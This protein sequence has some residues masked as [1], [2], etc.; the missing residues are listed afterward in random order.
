M[1]EKDSPPTTTIEHPI[2]YLVSLWNAVDSDG[3]RWKDRLRSFFLQLRNEMSPEG[4]KR[5]HW[6]HVG[7]ANSVLCANINESLQGIDVFNSKIETLE[8]QIN[9]RESIESKLL[10][11][12]QAASQAIFRCADHLTHLANEKEFTV[13]EKNSS[14]VHNTLEH[15]QVNKLF[16]DGVLEMLQEPTL[17]RSACVYNGNKRP[18]VSKASTSKA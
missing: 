14:F 17:L 15:A 12:L 4:L 18:C 13:D 11:E 10:T 9:N 16:L 8:K 7:D 1:S 5:L 3:N 2:T 6:Q